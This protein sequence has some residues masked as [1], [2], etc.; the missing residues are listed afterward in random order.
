VHTGFGRPCR[1]ERPP[2]VGKGVGVQE[3]RI[4][5]HEVQDGDRVWVQG[6]RMTDGLPGNGVAPEQS[7]PFEVEVWHNVVSGADVPDDLTLTYWFEL[8]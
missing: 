6:T 7:R 8:A 4:R 2:S 5:N 3:F 1:Q